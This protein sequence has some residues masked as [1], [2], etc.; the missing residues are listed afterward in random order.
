[1]KNIIIILFILTSTFQAFAQVDTYDVIDPTHV[2]IRK[3]GLAMTNNITYG[4]TVQ[5]MVT[6]FGQ[7]SSTSTEY[8]EMSDVNVNV[9][10]YG[11]DATFT[12]ENSKLRLIEIF[13]SN[14]Y[15]GK[16]GHLVYIK[17]GENI[18]TLQSTF[19]ISYANRINH[20]GAIVLRFGL[21]EAVIVVR[22]NPSTHIITKIEQSTGS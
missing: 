7:Y 20:H 10:K 12:F 15:I 2:I 11:T 9:Y 3:T 21:S 4:S 8:W 18:S 17:P 14:F 19:P 1:M 5:D 6:A 16:V 13:N 22:Y